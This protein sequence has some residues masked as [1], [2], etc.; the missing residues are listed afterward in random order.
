MTFEYTFYKHAYHKKYIRIVVKQH[1][2]LGIHVEGGTRYLW[3]FRIYNFWHYGHKKKSILF[4]VVYYYRILDLAVPFVG[5]HFW[6]LLIHQTSLKNAKTQLFWHLT[7]Q[8]R[9]LCMSIIF[10]MPHT[11]KRCSKR[12]KNRCK[13][14]NESDDLAH[15]H[16]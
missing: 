11:T 4:L 10:L 9:E 7:Y 6:S 16:F 1:E 3:L 12:L 5:R 13:S 14:M 8:R 15:T 2:T